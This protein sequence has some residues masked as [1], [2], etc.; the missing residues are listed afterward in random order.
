MA[1]DAEQGKTFAGIVKEGREISL[2]F[3]TAGQI[4]NVYVKEGDRVSK[5]TLLAALDDSDYMIEVEALR[6][7]ESQMKAELERTRRL[8]EQKGVSPNDFEKLEAGYRQVAARLEG[9]E[10][11]VKYTRL[12]APA[13]C[14]VQDVK[15]VASEMV[16]AGTPVFELLDCSG[17]DV[18][19]D[20]PLAL[21]RERG[22]IVSFE[23]T[24]NGEKIPLRL[25]SIAPKADS[26]QLYRMKLA[27]VGTH[28]ALTPGMNIEVSVAMSGNGS[29]AAV[30]LPAHS[31]VRRNDS[32]FVFVLERDSVARLRAVEL[33][34]LDPDGR[35]VVKSGLG[36]GE[37]FIRSGVNMIADGDI[38][39]VIGADGAAEFHDGSLM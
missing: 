15:F 5:G 39:S 10:N 17:I 35:V 13:D 29:P 37:R 36:S 23:G 8:L 32:T 14:Y 7:Q 24:A 38:V 25:V 3:K 11:K 19:L 27:V 12:Y 34:D 28:P 2:A 20:I 6:A 18:E 21:Y 30:T 9:A 33:G 4:S 22:N 31:V 26:N 16:N 1:T